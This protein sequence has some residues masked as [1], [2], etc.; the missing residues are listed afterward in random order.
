M[1][2]AMVREYAGFERSVLH[3]MAVSGVKQGCLKTSLDVLAE[4]KY[5][6]A[7][8]TLQR[9]L[10]DIDPDKRDYFVRKLK[11]VKVMTA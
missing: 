7:N 6:G 5:R 1:S 2:K 3:D 10:N 4:L 8:T 11:T 9:T